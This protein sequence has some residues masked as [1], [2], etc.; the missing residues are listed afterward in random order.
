VLAWKRVD[1]VA[2]RSGQPRINKE[3]TTFTSFCMSCHSRRNLVSASLP[4]NNAVREN[5]GSTIAA[6]TSFHGQL[7]RRTGE[8]GPA[9][10]FQV[11]SFTT[12]PFKGNPACVVVVPDRKQSSEQQ[13][14]WMQNVAAENN[15]PVTAFISGCD[16]ATKQKKDSAIDIRW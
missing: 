11:D 16:D 7:S 12:I 4:R 10:Q 8:T 15:I 2:R 1:I 13:Q 6:V 3:L 9:I 14:A 5:V